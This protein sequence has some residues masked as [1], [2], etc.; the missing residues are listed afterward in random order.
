MLDIKDRVKISTSFELK[1]AGAF[2]FISEDAHFIRTFKQSTNTVEKWRYRSNVLNGRGIV[3]PRNIR[4]KNDEQKEKVSL[5]FKK[6]SCNAF[7]HEDA[8]YF[9]FFYNLILNQYGLISLDGVNFYPNNLVA[10]NKVTNKA[11]SFISFTDEVFDDLVKGDSPRFN[12]FI[13]NM[14]NILR[15]NYNRNVLNI[16]ITK[17]HS[18][19]LNSGYLRLA[20]KIPVNSTEDSTKSRFNYRIHELVAMAYGDQFF[21]DRYD[22]N[23]IKYATHHRDGNPSNNKAENVILMPADLHLA[24]HHNH[25][26]DY[27]GLATDEEIVKLKEL[28]AEFL[29]HRGLYEFEGVNY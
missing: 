6:E 9:Y 20:I 18:H 28:R 11:E 26:E 13:G 10:V 3:E 17:G 21:I 16:G 22:L 24:L 14:G 4:F 23:Y 5:K 8:D 1:S 7:C 19:G 29:Y 15:V 25:I 2:K 12:H 27:I